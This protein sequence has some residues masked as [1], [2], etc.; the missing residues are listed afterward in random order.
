MRYASIV[1][2]KAAKGGAAR[3]AFD[4][5]HA[6]WPDVTLSFDDFERY[7]SAHA[8]DG[9]PPE[10]HHGDMY[11]ACA[12]SLGDDDALAALERGA[13]AD[14]ARA[15]ATI[16]SS[17]AFVQEVLQTTRERPRSTSTSTT[18]FIAHA[19]NATCARSPVICPVRGSSGVVRGWR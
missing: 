3:A 6:T 10:T 16:D 15:V 2:E 14:I 4:V 1:P 17:E 9:V 8:A 18:T 19:A 11:L 5:G 12:C 7:F 13:L